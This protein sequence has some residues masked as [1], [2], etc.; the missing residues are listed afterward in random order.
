LAAKGEGTFVRIERHIFGSVHGYT[1]LAK[2]PGVV[3]EDCRIIESAVYAFG[4]TYDGD[5][6]RDL[7]V[8]PTFFTRV[9][10]GNRRGL[11]M[12]RVGQADDKGRP[13]LLFV[14]AI[15]TRRDW[16]AVLMGDL[17]QLVKVRDLWDWSGLYA[18][19]TLEIPEPRPKLHVS[20]RHVPAVLQL[21]SQIERGFASQKAVVV[22]DADFGAEH[23]RAIEMLIPQALRPL[24][25]TACRA[26][27]AEMAATLVT[28]SGD[29]SRVNFR[30]Q[31]GGALSPYAEALKAAGL[32]NGIV[33]LAVVVQYPG[34][35][36]PEED[37]PKVPPPAVAAPPAALKPRI[38]PFVAIGTGGA[39]VGL[40]LGVLL[41]RSSKSDSMPQAKLPG[42]ATQPA[43]GVSPAL[44][45]ATEPTARPTT[46][47]TERLQVTIGAPPATA[48]ATG[49][50]ALTVNGEEDE[51]ERL[52]QLEDSLATTQPERGSVANQ[53]NASSSPAAVSTS[54]T[55]APAP[56][57]VAAAPAKPALAVPVPGKAA[58]AHP[59]AG[60]PERIAAYEQSKVVLRERMLKSGEAADLRFFAYPGREVS[61]VA[62]AEGGFLVRA[63]YETVNEVGLRVRGRYMCR[64]RQLGGQAWESKLTYLD[65]ET[66]TSTASS[67][68][69]N[70]R[71]R[72]E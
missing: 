64:L 6:Y 50:L 41:A 4:Q 59:Q 71:G 27:S 48:P 37:E 62:T 38:G 16:D 25:T 69:T 14:T 52:R 68:V 30:P 29:T 26:V 24:F 18:L 55:T 72:H 10:P 34:F 46:R 19:P 53:S 66:P 3:P 23:V 61:V 28:V 36:A 15:L 65:P 20:R 21:L 12:V 44:A 56:S 31:E 9:F 51:R 11:T 35:G 54:P 40:L 2:S 33:P 7:K 60:D 49:A 39:A 5:F 63:N 13:T 1:T 42:P 67:P 17:A 22:D 57:A 58:A 43:P 32:E 70:S 8:S 45:M 47:P